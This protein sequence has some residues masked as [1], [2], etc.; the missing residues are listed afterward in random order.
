MS[1]LLWYSLVAG[2]APL[3]AATIPF[4]L[5]RNG[6]SPR[7]V[8]VLLGVSS[9]LLFAIATLELIPE[10]MLMASSVASSSSSPSTHNHAHN[11]KRA[12][13]SLSKFHTSF[14]PS[15]D[16]LSV[17]TLLDGVQDE[18][19]ISLSTRAV[20]KTNAQ[21]GHDHAHGTDDDDEDTT[22]LTA[23][24]K[25]T[26]NADDHGHAHDEEEENKE[27]R[28]RIAMA[29]IGMGFF[30][31]V[32]VDQIMS[33]SGHSHSHGVMGGDRHEPDSDNE[34]E[35]K[36]GHKKHLSHHHD[37]PPAEKQQPP[38]SLSMVAF[39]GL[40]VHSLID[41]VVMAGAFSANAEVG[42]RVA[43]AIVLH[44]FPDGFVMSSI[45]ASQPSFRDG[46]KGSHPF[47]WI[48]AIA[49]M[50]PLGSLLAALVLG[51]IP[52]VATGFVLGYGAG[53]FLF[54]VA[55]GILPE[56][57]HSQLHKR[58]TLMSIVV[59]YVGFVFVDSTFHAH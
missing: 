53:T 38:S 28:I 35:E 42:S 44:K 24:S 59:G 55:T 16:G 49:S 13:L 56:V 51:S 40:A 52:A 50:T 17:R 29:G 21:D 37:E 20:I 8:Q 47:L 1:G 36:G 3:I 9:G 22:T 30:T 43:L 7:T 23:T 15:D 14:Q 5:F 32:L 57:L 25:T 45:I 6:M 12:L 18:E 34:D 31:L 27:G 19:M 54:V 58:L 10:A 11:E 4:C 46:S 39:V 48:A 26:T 41:G 2:S 33:A